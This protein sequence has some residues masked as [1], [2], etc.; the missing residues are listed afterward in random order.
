MPAWT[1]QPIEHS[2]RRN[3]MSKPTNFNV[4]G[5]PV[6]IEVEDLEEPLT[7]GVEAFTSREYAKAEADQLWAKV[8]QMAG[9]VE[10]IPEVGN[11]I[12]YEIGDDS[13]LIVRTASDKVKAYHN[14]C[15]HRGRRLV[16]TP[17]GA[18][19]ACGMRKR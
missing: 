7:Y 11:Y 2:G 6:N 9:R 4:V 10:E 17:P 3:G 13:I 1:M 18:N 15:A 16:S 19:R 12:T 5:K 8:W 14:V